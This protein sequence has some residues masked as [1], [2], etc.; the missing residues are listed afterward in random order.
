M[1]TPHQCHQLLV[2]PATVHARVVAGTVEMGETMSTFPLVRTGCLL[3][4]ILAVLLSTVSGG[5]PLLGTW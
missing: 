2:G 4:C 3:R 1:T 5:V